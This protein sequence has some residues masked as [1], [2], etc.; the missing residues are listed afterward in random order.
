MSHEWYQV[1]SGAGRGDGETGGFDLRGWRRLARWS[2][3][4]SCMPDAER[5]QAERMFEEQWEEFCGW[6]VENYGAEVENGRN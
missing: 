1:V 2:L 3:E 6:I 4:Y 5:Q